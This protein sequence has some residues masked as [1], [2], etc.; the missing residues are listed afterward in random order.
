MRQPKMLGMISALAILLVAAGTTAE[1]NHAGEICVVVHPGNASA[2]GDRVALRQVF[3]TKVTRWSNGERITPL[4]LP[5]QSPHRGA[6]DRAV[7]GLSPEESERYWIDRKIRGGA[8][9]PATAPEPGAVVRVVAQSEGAIGYVP[10]SSLAS[11]VKVIARIR[12][13]K[14]VEP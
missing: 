13:G 3:Q 2:A 1:G 11:N 10:A 14:V 9:P 6:F 12:D 8:P 7:L 4:N 5:K